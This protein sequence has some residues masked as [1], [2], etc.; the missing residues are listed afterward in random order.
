MVQEGDLDTDGVAIEANSISLNG[1]FIKD[2]AGNDAILTHEAVP[3]DSAFKVDAVVPTVSSIAITSDPGD[4]DTYDAGDKIEVT[5][6]FS[7]NV[8]VPDC[9][10]QRQVI[11]RPRLE[12]DIGGEAKK[13][14]YQNHRGHR[15][16]LCLQRA[17]WRLRRRRE[18]RLGPTSLHLDGGII[19]D[20]AKNNPISATLGILELPLDAV[21][22]HDAL[23]DDSGHKVSGSSV[24]VDPE[25]PHDNRIQ[26]E[27]RFLFRPGRQTCRS[28][29]GVRNRQRRCLVPIR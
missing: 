10:A 7:E 21:V 9:R 27:Q 25:R 23:A 12:L 14:D 11:H 22:S 15:R 24:V 3:A 20:A 29:F 6:T 8:T 19:W 28:V 4:D 16:S 13:A 5:V 18:Y 2:Q 17:G 26:G 1:G